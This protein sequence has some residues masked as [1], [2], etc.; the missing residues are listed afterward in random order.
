MAENDNYARAR[1]AT[2][3]RSTWGRRFLTPAAS[4]PASVPLGGR[5]YAVGD[6]HGR[7]D[8]LQRLW[9]RIE[10]DAEGSPLHKVVVFVGDY[11]DRGPD[12]RGVVEFL[13]QAR[14]AGGV[15]LCLRGNHEQSLLD[16]M[17]NAA[18]YRDWK[19]FGAPE[20]LLSYGVM[21]PWFDDEAD[22]ERARLEFVR[23]CPLRH[24]RFLKSLT[25]SYVIGGYLFAHAGV[26]PG[27]ALDD[28][29]EEDLLWIRDEFLTS[30]MSFGKVVVHGHSPGQAPVRRANRIGIDTGAYATGCL[31]AAVLE[32]TDCRFLST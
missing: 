11:V 23:N 4:E 20:T 3:M 30:Q 15:V 27:I 14:I 17:D 6:V 10:A 12:S 1:P 24:V 19:A 13:M 21:P 8:L 32:G 2:T 25:H 18:I 7:L 26:R 28:Q 9:A 5:V 16:F 22:F 31:T 29:T